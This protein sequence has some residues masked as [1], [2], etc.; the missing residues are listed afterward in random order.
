MTDTQPEG[1]PTP[2]ASPPL[3]RRQKAKARTREKVLAAAAALFE[4]VGYEKAVI[5]DIAKR[6]GMSTGAVFANFED[7]AHLYETVT[8]HPPVSAEAGAHLLTIVR[9]LALNGHELSTEEPFGGALERLLV[10]ARGR[11]AEVW[12]EGL[13]SDVTDDFR[14][15]PE[16][17]LAALADELARE[18][19]R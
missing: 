19:G 17:A 6:A 13:R 8:G 3:N 2:E 1:W 18:P 10:L 7:K 9:S 14:V 11:V 5:R 15:T 4:E 16:E 12:P